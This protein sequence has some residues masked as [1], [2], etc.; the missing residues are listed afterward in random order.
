MLSKEKYIN[1]CKEDINVPVFSQPWWLDAVC[2]AENWEV[3]IVESNDEIIATFPYYYFVSHGFKYIGMPTLTQKLGMYIKYPAG[4][5]ISAKLSYEKEIL[6]K[7]ILELPTY[8]YF[9]IQCDY[10]YQNWLPFYWNHF[11]Q[12]T[13]YSYIIDDISDIEKVYSNFEYSKKKNIKKALKEM[14]VFFDLPCKD[15]Y[16]N[17]KMTLAKQ[18]EKISYSFKLFS[19]IY[20]AAYEHNQGRVIYCKDKNDNIHGALFII[21]DNNSAYDLISTLDPDFRNS[22]A[23]TLLVY[24]MIKSLS[25]KVSVFDFEG[26]M[27]EGVE[28]SF[29]KFGTIQKPYFQIFKAN[30]KRYRLLHAL[31]DIVYAIKG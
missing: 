29:R 13:K 25:E 9:N 30:S 18:G 14:E 1:F 24:E 2:G 20:D 3:I 28:N 15:F 16:E 26:S 4:Q 27:I 6:N 22:G 8:D 31:R 21:W 23:S 10:K 17:H 11:Q 7:I 12:T 19:K 5:S